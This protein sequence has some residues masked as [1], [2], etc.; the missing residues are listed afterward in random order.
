MDTLLKQNVATTIPIMMFGTDGVTPLISIAVGNLSVHAMYADGTSHLVTPTSWVEV[1]SANLPGLY[2]IGI[3]IS[4]V[5]QIGPLVIFLKS[6]VPSSDLSINKYTVTANL[7]DDLSTEVSS[8]STTL[9]GVNTTVNNINT[10]VTGTS[11][12]VN[13]INTTVTGTS[14]HVLQLRRLAEG[15]WK[16]FNTGPD[17]NRLVLYSAD[18]VTVLQKWDLKDLSG[19]PTT[20]TIYERVP[21][22]AIP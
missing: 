14:T 4:V 5:A 21:T 17:A 1:D 15:H 7:L 16:I 19:A 12:T 18:G 9:S 13:G 2:M 3:G 6:S 8:V 22:V 11:T 20:S 10:T